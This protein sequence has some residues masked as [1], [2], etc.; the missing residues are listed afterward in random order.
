MAYIYI[1]T[2]KYLGVLLGMVSGVNVRLLCMD[3]T[4]NRLHDTAQHHA[5]PVTGS[6]TQICRNPQAEKENT[7]P[8]TRRGTLRGPRSAHGLQEKHHVRQVGA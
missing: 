8:V 5:D 4:A 2:Y 7:H 3:S 1:Y 6:Q